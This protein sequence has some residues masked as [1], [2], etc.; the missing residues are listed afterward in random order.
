MAEL[1]VFGS[2]GEKEFCAYLDTG[3]TKTLIP[4]KDALG[5]GLSY[6]GETAF[7]TASGEDA[8]RLYA[9]EVEFMGRRHRIL[10]LGRDLLGKVSIKS[11]VGR[12]ILDQYRVC[13]NGRRR[14]LEI[15]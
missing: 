2:R 5:L 6:V 7:M 13:F 4:E 9:A 1:K 14:E 12:D 10:V 3:A 8:F 11:I 15:T